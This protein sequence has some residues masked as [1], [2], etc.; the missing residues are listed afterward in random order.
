M[1]AQLHSLAATHSHVRM[2]YIFVQQA[3]ERSGRMRPDLPSAAARQSHKSTRSRTL[4]VRKMHCQM[5]QDNP[6]CNHHL[7]PQTSSEP[8][9]SWSAHA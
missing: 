1:Q 4:C 2:L 6:F 3:L 9:R 7:H 5:C 8:T